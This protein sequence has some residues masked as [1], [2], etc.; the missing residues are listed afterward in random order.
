MNDFDRQEGLIFEV[1]D[2][3]YAYNDRILALD[4]IDMEIRAGETL[5]ILGSNGSGK[6]TLLKLLDGL[7]Y[8]TGGTVKAFGQVL[9]EQAFQDNRFNYA[10]RAKIGLVFQDSNVQ[11]FMPSVWDEVAF[12]PLQSGLSP[13]EVQGRVADALQALQIEK[14]K[15]RPPHQLS[16]G[17]KKRVALASVLS[18]APEVWLL[19]EPSAGLDPRSA[20]WL[21]EFIQAQS[22]AGNTL[23]IATHDL[24]LVEAT[25]Q[26]VYALNEA[27]QILA[28]GA[29]G[30]IL[31]DRALLASANLLPLGF[32]SPR[33]GAGRDV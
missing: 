3:C 6:S 17:E 8:P 29:A 12:A 24:S 14:L 19:D 28:G 21:V 23:V 5:A 27:H 13:T 33:P 16:E 15:D 4:H 11:L 26:R 25:A 22:R 9:S 20:A 30:Q 10:F 2:L 31:R 18:L 1:N 32:S 7:Y